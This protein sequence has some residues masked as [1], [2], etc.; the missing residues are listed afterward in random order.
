MADVHSDYPFP[1]PVISITPTL[2]AAM[3]AK[4]TADSTTANNAYAAGCTGEQ[5]HYTYS[6]TLGT[7]KQAPLS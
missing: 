7:T 4:E 6:R 3:L 5:F 2:L 1:L